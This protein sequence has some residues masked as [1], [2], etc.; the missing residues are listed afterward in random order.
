MG[1]TEITFLFIWVIWVICIIF[2][3][4]VRPTFSKFI[5]A[6]I[7]DTVLLGIIYAIVHML[8]KYW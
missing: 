5:A 2:D 8:L 6:V 3:L 4:I 1:T 7:G